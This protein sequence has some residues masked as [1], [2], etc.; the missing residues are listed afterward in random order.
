MEP[1]FPFLHYIGQHGEEQVFKVRG[2]VPNLAQ[3]Q[4]VTPPQCHPHHCPPPHG[5]IWTRNSTGLPAQHPSPHPTCQFIPDLS[6]NFSQGL[7]RKAQRGTR[8]GGCSSVSL[9]SE[10]T[11]AHTSSASCS[12]T[13]ILHTELLPTFLHLMVLAIVFHLLHMLSRQCS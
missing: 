10:F 11:A 8:P 6:L 7:W 3:A 12:L 1:I 9:F 4:P 13:G 5:M 2:N